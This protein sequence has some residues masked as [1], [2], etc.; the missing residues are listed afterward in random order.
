MQRMLVMIAVVVLVTV[1]LGVGSLAAHWPFWQRA[2]QWHDSS[3]GWPDSIGGISQ[4]L[5]GGAEP[6]QLQFRTEPQLEAMA[7]TGATQALLRAWSD[8]RVDAWFASGID[9]G[10][11]VDWRGMS[12]VLLAPLY[13]QFVD[14]QPDLLDRPAGAWLATWSEDRRGA[15]TPRQ[16]FWQLSGMPAGDFEPLNP[17]NARA[18]LVAGPDFARAALRWQPEWPP[19]SHF[20]ESPVNAQ[21]LAL[22]AARI[23]GTDFT[24]VLQQRLWSR[25]AAGDAVVMMDHRRG[26]MA[27]HCCVRTSI[28]DW[29][30]L[31]LLLA[32]DGRSG[33]RQL[34]PAGLMPK[35]LTVSP[36]HAGYGLGF[37][38]QGQEEDRQLL[39]ASTAGRYL[40]IAP[41]AAAVLLWV[42]EG[43]PPPGLARLLP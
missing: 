37:Q 1:S 27:A 15:I 6:L 42:G 14:E 25:I 18:Q 39:V 38:L 9:A 28:G 19:G 26:D 4:I 43:T 40:V 41:R 11:V 2:W 22:L 5:K 24:S 10:L 31:A 30:R 33:A 3:T 20:E 35:L 7:A 36:V 8:G 32:A 12:P 29:L 34:W 13:A 17:F 16:F 21:L 23:D